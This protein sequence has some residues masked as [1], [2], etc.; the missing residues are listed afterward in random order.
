MA[1]EEG[2]G[3]QVSIKLVMFPKY[4]FL[5]QTNN[6]GWRWTFYFRAHMFSVLALW[7]KSW[8]WN[9]FYCWYGYPFH[10]IGKYPEI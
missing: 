5:L 7:D 9:T 1:Q 8:V 2:V 6:T 10:N 3:K 4:I